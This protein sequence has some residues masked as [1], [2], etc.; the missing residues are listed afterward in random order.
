[1]GEGRLVRR[2]QRAVV[3]GPDLGGVP[4][5]HQACAARCAEGKGGVRRVVAHA[6]LHQPVQVGRPHDGMAVR[7]GQCGDHL[8][9]KDEQYVGSHVAL[10]LNRSSSRSVAG[11][12]AIDSA[13]TSSRISSD[14]AKVEG[15]EGRLELIQ[16]APADDRRRHVG[17]PH[18]PGDSQ[19]H[20][21][22]APVAGMAHEA[23]GDF[24]EH[25]V[26]VALHVVVQFQETTPR[27]PLVD[28]VLAGQQAA[29]EGTVGDHAQ[30]LRAGQRQDFHLH[31]P[32]DQAVH[33]LNAG[34]GGQPLAGAVAK[35]LGDLPGGPV[36]HRRVEDLAAAHQVVEGGEG[37]LHRRV[38]V[39]VVN[40]VQV[41]AVRPQPPETG[42][43][44]LHDMPARQAPVVGAVTDRIADLRSDD[45][46]IA[47]ALD[48]AAQDLLGEPPG[49]VV[50]RVEEV[51]PQVAAVAVHLPGGRLVRIAA[52]GHGTT[53]QA[54][55]L[56]ARAAQDSVLHLWVLLCD[57]RALSSLPGSGA[58]A[59]SFR[60]RFGQRGHSAPRHHQHLWAA[61]H[62]SRLVRESGW[63]PRSRRR[64]T[65]RAEAP[66]SA[67]WGWSLR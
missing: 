27:R 42:L 58:D 23:L 7:P 66:R 56:D 14:M 35:G 17:M 4:S 25:G 46:L 67:C 28:S 1:M 2:Q 62:R 53:A 52:E 41:E 55:H 26:G 21:M 3:P 29:P 32:L 45:Q 9:R 61:Q 15:G 31:L 33:G 5:R 54:G 6:L 59:A 49:I 34:E 44:G 37:F 40:E 65:S 39:E 30:A 48:Q 47:L 63:R 43:Y 57:P 13:D 64:P 19:G 22:H 16:I 51:D 12:G 11:G 50:G 38:V 18:G 60:H 10:P 20:R 36:A 8:V 24:V